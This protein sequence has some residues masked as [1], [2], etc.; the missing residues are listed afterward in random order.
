MTS[1]PDSTKHQSGAGEVAITMELIAMELIAMASIAM[2]L[3][4]IAVTF[5]A[6]DLLCT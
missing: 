6:L 4:A 3:I 5:T 2:T 1:P